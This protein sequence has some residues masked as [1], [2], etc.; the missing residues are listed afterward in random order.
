M[1]SGADY[2]F[3]SGG[4]QIPSDSAVLNK[5]AAHTGKAAEHEDCGQWLYR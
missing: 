3:P 4:W 5:V 2:M 1:T